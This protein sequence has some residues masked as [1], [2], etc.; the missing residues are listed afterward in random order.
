MK[1]SILV[2]SKKFVENCTNFNSFESF[3]GVINRTVIKNHVEKLASEIDLIGFIG[4]IIVIQTKAF[5]KTL[6][7][8]IIDGQNRLEALRKLGIPFNYQLI[9]LNVDT[10]QN[11][12]RLITGLNSTTVNWSPKNYLNAY[13]GIREYDIFSKHLEEGKGVIGITDLQKIFSVS[14]K[15][16]NSGEM[17]FENMKKSLQTLCDVKTMLKFLPN[18]TDSK[19]QIFK[20]IKSVDNSKILADSI[21]KANKNGKIFTGSRKELFNEI[22][23]A[24]TSYE[25]KIAA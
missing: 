7:K 5:G 17:K 22:I 25:M 16:Y 18:H 4:V 12:V 10:K 20:A 23:E 15:Q 11:V 14:K 6:K 3:Q 13:D 8:Y 21:V 19:R 2:K 24:Y 9:T 1:K